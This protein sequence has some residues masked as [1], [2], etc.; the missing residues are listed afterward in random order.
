MK[1]LAVQSV[2]KQPL[3]ASSIHPQGW[4]P[5]ET[6]SIANWNGILQEMEVAFTPKGG[7]PLKQKAAGAAGMATGVR[8]VAFTPKGGCPLKREPLQPRR[9][10]ALLVAFTP[11]GGCPLKQR[12]ATC[13]H[14]SR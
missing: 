13:H 14:P 8:P 12:R 3:V 11:K 1:Q 9:V 7:C 10:P 2:L 5:I 4:V 6:L